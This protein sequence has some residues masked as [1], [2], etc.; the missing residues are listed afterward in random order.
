MLRVHIGIVGAIIAVAVQ[1]VTAARPADLMLLSWERSDGQW[2]FYIMPDNRWVWR[3][4]KGTNDFAKQTIAFASQG[5]RTRDDI[6]R[7]LALYAHTPQ[8]IIWARFIGTELQYPPF[9]I[10]ADIRGFAKSQ[11]VQLT[12]KS[13]AKR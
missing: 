11:G 5:V 1:H 7:Q 4:H 8:R 6:K 13:I 2:V 9:E 3:T 12:M 10:S